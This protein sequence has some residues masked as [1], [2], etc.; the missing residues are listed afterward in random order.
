M[1]T[2]SLLLVIMLVLVVSCTSTPTP[3]PIPPHQGCDVSITF[4]NEPLGSQV[5]VG[6][7]SSF[8]TDGVPIIAKA[9]TWS[10]G[11]PTTGGYA[12]IQNTGKAGGQGQEVFINNVNLLF[13]FG[14]GRALKSLKMIYFKSGGNLNL[15]INDQFEYK[16]D[17]FVTINASNIGGVMVN[18]QSLGAGKGE[19]D[20]EGPMTI[21]P[22][23]DGQIEIGG[24]EL[25]FDNI[26]GVYQ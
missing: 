16:I 26:C 17:D 9:F 2:T 1:N 19:I 21:I 25:W 13:S 12:E 7:G 4:D 23:T 18:V 20:F 15:R 5:K 24:Q 11:T 3:I 8:Q 10:S 6:N 14:A 22:D